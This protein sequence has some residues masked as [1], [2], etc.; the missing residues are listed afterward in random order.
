[1]SAGKSSSWFYP[2]ATGDPGRDRNTQTLQFA[3]FLLASA[4]GGLALL[5][6]HTRA[7]P[8][9]LF[10]VASL[11]AA[12]AIN[13]AGRTVWAARIAFVAV[14]SAAILLVFEARDGFRSLA[15]LAFPGLLL[16]TVM[17]MDRVSYAT[18][19]GIILAAVA[20]LG[21]AEMHG[22]T[23]AI[24]RSRTV[25]DYDSIVFVDMYLLV[26]ALIGGRI[27]RDTQSNVADLRTSVDRLSAMNRELRESTEALRVSEAKY[28]RL[29][30]SITDALVTVDMAGHILEFN[31]A[32][33]GMLGYT[34]DELR[35]STYEDITPDR[36]HAFEARI[37]A[38][39][40]LP[41]GHSAV[42][43][44]EYRRRDGSVVPIEL[45]RCLI[46][47]EEGR[48]K[49]MWAIVRDITGRRRNERAISEGERRLRLAK[50]AAKLGIYE[51]DITTGTILWDARVRELWGVGPD[52]PITIDT[53]FAGLHPDDRPRIQGRLQRAVDPEGN[54]EYYGE[55]RVIGRIDGRE[56]W[57]AA[58]GQVFFEN[59]RAVRMVGTGKDI[60]ER[61][62]AEEELR[63]SEERFRNMADTAPVMIWVTGPDKA[64]TFVNR[65]WLDFTGRTMEQELGFGWAECVH[66]DDRD[67]NY[68]RF[69][70][71]FDA[72]QTFQVESR[73]RRADGEYR[74][75][76]CTGV[77]RFA[78]GGS[79][80]G[81][82]GSKIDITDLQSEM[83]FR[84]LAENIDQ[85]FWMLDIGTQRVLYVS[86]A[87]EKVWGIRSAAA[88]HGPDWWM[89]SI[90]PED[91]DRCRAFAS[92]L[93]SEAAQ[94]T[95][96]IVRPDGSVRWIHD[97]AFLVYD[98][99]GKPYRVAG[100]AEDVTAHR[101]LEEEL[102]QAYKMEA[103][104]R[105]A[106]GIAHDFNNLLTV[107]GG[108]LHLVLAATPPSDPRHDKLKHILAASNRASTLTSQLLAFSRKQMVQPK[109]VNVNDLLTNMEALLRPVMG[110]HIHLATD[111]GR[112]LP[113]VKADPNQLEQVLINLAANARDAMP[114]GGEFLIR[115]SAGDGRG[116]AGSGHESGPCV[117]IQISDTGCGMSSNVLKHVF[118]PFFTTKEVGKGTG[119][120][121]STVYGII[122]QNHGTIHVSSHPDRGTTFEIVLPAAAED[123]DAKP[124]ASPL[125]SLSGTET[126]L[127][128]EDEPGVRNLVCEMLEQLGYRVLQAADGC[129]ALRVLEQQGPVDVLL[130]DVIMPALGGPELAKR[131]RSMA[132]GTKV[133]YMSGY[134][135]D[136]LANYGLA[137]PGT[138]YIQ[139]PFTPVDLAE[140]LRQVLGANLRRAA[141]K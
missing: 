59:G 45:R 51:Y 4:I 85:V 28:R 43:E 95:Y 108:Y 30:E 74:L 18:T 115:T 130:T 137:Q 3:C 102:R 12:G 87:F 86:P 55:Y 38:E 135:D 39:Q 14:L 132:P 62:Q 10:A 46:R 20:A 94:E 44:K 21:I 129:E 40:V 79:F 125:E 103:I 80:A 76:L 96:R 110:E 128:A 139:K 35:R 119:L 33:E 124:A 104:G 97:R 24:P 64:C 134:T 56:R 25:T 16:I 70:A 116:Q 73:W 118:E 72:R 138:A 8:L 23:S 27:A 93:K 47:D 100:L 2:K 111:L 26:I 22:L 82:I 34:A 15:M 61:K 66:P 126:I 42:Y 6:Q 114:K 99:D 122:Q 52:E 48:P 101:E 123:E 140:K 11:V 136:A 13:R 60:T 106:G 92:K 5:Y 117:R 77:P 29:Y 91:R 75:V 83:R 19:A 107:V 50:D 69:S 37:V 7:T 36:W 89:S 41:H 67:R 78:P 54:G 131:V 57:V 71:A 112:D 109:A 17:L 58:S 31:P 113:C 49:G 133:I 1:M 90:H 120:G 84:Q 9:L 127:V 141:G 81:Y 63:E 105:L 98:S 53:F 88:Y 32:F 68:E 121:L 65:T